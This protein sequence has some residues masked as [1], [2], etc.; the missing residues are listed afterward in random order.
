VVSLK[1]PAAQPVHALAP[2]AE[3][4]PSEQLVQ[5]APDEAE[6]VPEMQSAHAEVIDGE[7]LP[8]SHVLQTDAPVS[9]WYWPEA[10]L[11]QPAAEPDAA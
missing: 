10:Q 11:A 5:A 1:V 8:L 4:M 9:N 6:K 7:N 2:A 3:Y